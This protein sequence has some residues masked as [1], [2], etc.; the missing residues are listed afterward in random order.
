MAREEVEITIDKEG[1]VSFE[2]KGVKGR[3]CEA[4]TKKL[5]EGL[6]KVTRRKHKKEWYIREQQRLKQ[7]GR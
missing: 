1:N 6:G 2:V 5:E 4:L 7:K 3:G